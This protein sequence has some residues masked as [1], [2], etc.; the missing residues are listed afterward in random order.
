MKLTVRIAGFKENDPGI[1]RMLDKKAELQEFCD[2]YES[3]LKEQ[4]PRYAIDGVLPTVQIVPDRK[5]MEMLK[6]FFKMISVGFFVNQPQFEWAVK[7]GA[8][9]CRKVSCRVAGSIG[10]SFYVCGLPKKFPAD[11]WNALSKNIGEFYRRWTDGCDDLP[12]LI[13]QLSDK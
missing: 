2:E 11:K 1:Q 13:Y 10:V 6:G 8:L 9:P 4:L 7:N 12:G 5:R 3:I